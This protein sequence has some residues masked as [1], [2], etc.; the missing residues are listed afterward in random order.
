MGAEGRGPV[1]PHCTELF[2]GSTLDFIVSEV[3]KRLSKRMGVLAVE[4][5][6]IHNFPVL[7]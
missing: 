5:V 3:R 6:Y 4:L 1:G 2:I 7:L